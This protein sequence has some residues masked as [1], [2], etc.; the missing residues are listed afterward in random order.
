MSE[1]C[2]LL[3]RYETYYV[4]KEFMNVE[5]G[6]LG[7]LYILVDSGRIACQYQV[8][9]IKIKMAKFIQYSV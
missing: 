6:C 8:I 3:Y 1:M 4:R 2:L 7:C 5:R 9:G